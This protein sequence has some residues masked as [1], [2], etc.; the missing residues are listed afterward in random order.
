MDVLQSAKYI[1]DNAID[2]GINAS[3]VTNAA[4][5]IH[6]KMNRADYSMQTWS[7]HELHPKIKNDAALEFVFFVD[8]MN[9]SFWS[10]GNEKFTVNYR[11][12]DYTGYWSLCALVHRAIDEGIPVTNPTFWRQAGDNALRRVFR[13]DSAVDIPL[14]QERMHVIRE[15]GQVLLEKFGDSVHEIFRAADGS[16]LELVRIVTSEFESFRDQCCFEGEM[17]RIYKRAQIL[18]AD[19]WACFEGTSWGK[20]RDIDEITMFADYRV[21][22][23]LHTL[24]CLVYS[25]RLTHHIQ[26]GEEI[27]WASHWEIEIRGCSIWAV[28]LIKR[29]IQRQYPN[30]D[31]NAILLDFYLWD[32]AKE[33]E[34]SGVSVL[35]PH[36]TRSVFY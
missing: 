25:P 27:L 13:S 32:H 35:Q 1:C 11:G 20:F 18:V 15:S 23:I 3:G 28:E 5:K 4:S 7:S 19:A 33:Q 14:L 6:E 17:V 10:P 9:F 31:I 12:K 30:V 22:Q 29:Q 16:A 21:P 26:K 34:S 24:G 8:L 2:V 36:R